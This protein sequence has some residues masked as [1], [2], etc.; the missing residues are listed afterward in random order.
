MMTRGRSTAQRN[1]NRVHESDHAV[2]VAL[3]AFPLGRVNLG[4]LSDKFEG[5]GKRSDTIAFRAP[6]MRHSRFPHT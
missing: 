5:R 1:D 4:V 3:A 6:P 2:V